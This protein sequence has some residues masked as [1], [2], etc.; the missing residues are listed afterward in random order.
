VVVRWTGSKKGE[1]ERVYGA[2][3]AFVV[4]DVDDDDDDMLWGHHVSAEALRV[5]VKVVPA[6]AILAQA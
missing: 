5:R 6:G 4:D 1:E 3:P 2:V